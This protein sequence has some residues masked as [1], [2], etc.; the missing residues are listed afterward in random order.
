M[1]ARIGATGLLALFGGCGEG[2]VE[3]L[4]PV[5]VPAHHRTAELETAGGHAVHLTL[6]EGPGPAPV[7]LFAHANVYARCELHQ[8]YP[9]LHGAWAEA[10]WVVASPDMSDLCTTNSGANLASRRDRLGEARSA[11]AEAELPLALDLSRVVA[12]GHSRGGSAALLYRQ[13][14]PELLGVMALMPVDPDRFGHEEAPVAGP[15]LVLT[16]ANDRDLL[17]PHVDVIEE[18]LVGPAAWI[19]L[20]RGIHAWVGDFVP[21]YPWDEPALK[22]EAQLRAV[23]ALTTAFLDALPASPGAPVAESFPDSHDEAA[24]LRELAGLSLDLRWRPHPEEVVLIDDFG[25]EEHGGDGIPL[26][27]AAGGYNSAEGLAATELFAYSPEDAFPRQFD[28][29]VRALQ[30]TG[31]RAPGTWWSTLP[32]LTV[33]PEHTRLQATVRVPARV[34]PPELVE[35]VLDYRDA[36]GA[37]HERARAVAELL[38]PS[39]LGLHRSQLDLPLS[40]LAPPPVRLEGVGLRVAGGTVQVDD[41]R[42]VRPPPSPAEEVAPPLNDAMQTPGTED[43]TEEG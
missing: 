21:T 4:A 14:A 25:L 28:R 1:R 31:S 41:L 38:G 27:N 40:D 13:Q 10:G 17:F 5:V 34:V 20:R 37:R 32:D 3:D 24:A 2:A 42:L 9:T 8:A 36:E 7:I 11:L 26:T 22:K 6:P 33:D 16:G 19:R 43:G 35:V 30:L 15:V 39:R 18:Q 29:K 12:A 23:A